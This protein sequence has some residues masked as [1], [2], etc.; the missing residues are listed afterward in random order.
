MNYLR[1]LFTTWRAQIAALVSVEEVEPT[2][3]VQPSS[4]EQISIRL[5]AL[6]KRT[7]ADLAAR[8][9]RIK[10]LSEAIQEAEK[11]LVELRVQLD[12]EREA[13]L[14]D[15]LLVG[16]ELD[17]LRSELAD[18]CPQAVD[19][20]LQEVSAEIEHL[21]RKHEIEMQANIRLAE[22]FKARGKAE[23]LRVAPVPMAMVL[24][25]LRRLEQSVFTVNKEGNHGIG[26]QTRAWR[27]PG[28]TALTETVQK[29]A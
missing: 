3:E 12:A 13:K 21:Q 9:E 19:V 18:H 8:L 5:L 28:S 20:F 7:E 17:K 24:T 22:L 11:P 1:N 6:Q 26:G 14:A 29:Y 15:S 10:I 2:P 4:R 25:E 16:V 23:S 27:K